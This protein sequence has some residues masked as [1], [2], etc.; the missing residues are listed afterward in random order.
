MARRTR[1]EGRNCVEH[2]YLI[3]QV[4]KTWSPARGTAGQGPDLVVRILG[5]G[6]LNLEA[7]DD[8]SAMAERI[9]LATEGRSLPG[10]HFHQ[11]KY[12][13]PSPSTAFALLI[14]QA[15]EEAGGDISEMYALTARGEIAALGGWTLPGDDTPGGGAA[16]D[17]EN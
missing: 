2:A 1:G 15:I 16:P 5:I 12:M 7:L 9:R 11:V 6:G 13:R 3:A 8:W 4:S 10:L 14:G 17:T